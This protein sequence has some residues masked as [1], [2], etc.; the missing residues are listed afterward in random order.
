MGDRIEA[1]A[2]GAA[3]RP[4]GADD[5]AIEPCVIG[6]VKSNLGH[7][8]SAAGVAGLL[9][10]ILAVHHG[11]IPASI[12]V[13]RP[14]PAIDFTGLNLAVAQASVPW[15]VPVDTR[16][17]GVSSFGF[18]GTNAHVVVAGHQE[19]NDCG[20]VGDQPAL[21]T[22]SAAD[23]AALAETAGRWADWID[24]TAPPLAD[25]VTTAG[26][27]TRHQHRVA[28]VGATP[29]G[30]AAE[31]R[32]RAA[33][34]LPAAGSPR[35][36]LVFSGQGPS[37]DGHAAEL[38]ESEP[39]FASIVHRVD[40]VGQ[41]LGR[42]QGW[43]VDPIRG[44][45]AA[46]VADQR[47]MQPAWFAIQVGLA[48][49]W[50]AAGV[51]PA[52]LLGHSLGEV[53]AAN[54]AGCLDL[55]TAARVACVRGEAAANLM[56][57]R[58]G[59]VATDLNEAEARDELSR[60]GH[61]LTVAA[62]NSPL[63]TAFAGG[64]DALVELVER[65][66]AEG[67]FAQR[68]AL[69][70]PSHSPL[71]A[72]AAD[73]LGEALADVSARPAEVPL[74]SSVTADWLEG[75]STDGAYWR[76]NLRHP[77][78]FATAAA[79]LFSHVDVV[80]ELA[81]QPTIVRGLREVAAAAGRGGDTLVV[82]AS[83]RT[84]PSRV[85][86]LAATGDL[87]EAG[88]GVTVSR[89]QDVA[90]RRRCAPGYAWQRARAWSDPRGTR[91]EPTDHELLG[92]KLAIAAVSD[93]SVWQGRLRRETL[94]ST[95]D[96][97]VVGDVVV[98]AAGMVDALAEAGRRAGVGLG[99]DHVVE[100]ADVR[101]ERF[102][103]VPDPGPLVQTTVQNGEPLTG[104][105]QV[106]LHSQ[107]AADGRWKRHARAELRAGGSVDGPDWDDLAIETNQPVDTT[108][109]YDA[110]AE[111]GVEYGPAH[112][113]LRQ[114]RRGDGVAVGSLD[115]RGGDTWGAVDPTCLDG[116]FQLIASAVSRPDGGSGLTVPVGAKAIRLRPGA[117]AEQAAV[118]LI[119]ESPS[120]LVADVWLYD[121]DGRPSAAVEGLVARRTSF[122]LRRD[123]AGAW[124]YEVT[125]HARPLPLDAVP[126]ARRWLVVGEGRH[127]ERL[128]TGL[129]EAGGPEVVVTT[130][131]DLEESLAAGGDQATG[132][133]LLATGD[134]SAEDP[135]TRAAALTWA[136][137]EVIRAVSF[138]P[139]TSTPRLVFLTS[140]T[141]DVG[142]GISD[143]AGAVL[144]GLARVVPFE[145][146]RLDC[147]LLDGAAA[148]VV[149]ELLRGDDVDVAVRDGK[150]YVAQLTPA[151]PF[152][153][154][155]ATGFD[156]DPAGSYVITGGLGGI[157]LG[158]AHHL[159]AR[160]ARRLALLGRS[161]PGPAAAAAVEALRTD[162]AEVLVAAVDVADGQGLRSVLADVRSTL[163]P[164]RGVAHA[165]G[166][167]L[168]RAMLDLTAPDVEA[169]LRPKVAGGWNLQQAVAG[170]RLDWFVSFSS[171]SGVI[172]SPG[173]AAYCAAN[174]FLD[175]LAGY[176]SRTIAIDWGPWARIGIV[177]GRIANGNDS[178]S[179]LAAGLDPDL[180]FAAFDALVVEQPRPRVLLPYDLADLL[181]YHPGGPSLGF[182]APILRGRQ[183]LVTIGARSGAR[184]RP[185]L[186]HEV[187]APSTDVERRIVALWQAALGLDQI[188]VTDGFFELG[189]DSVLANQVFMS[190]NRE[191]GVSVDIEAAFLEATVAH[192]ATLVE[193]A[194]RNPA[195]PPACAFQ[196]T[197]SQ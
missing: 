8:E 14:N 48:S 70:P 40:E 50:R 136:G 77:V 175:A 38:F 110:F 2:L 45:S 163:G 118:R 132:V 143:P 183:G 59:L 46:R 51:R 138:A 52:M 6:S 90:G 148:E 33:G 187:V 116:A 88:V 134:S 174:A 127:A 67:R 24:A 16:I 22:L 112:R 153:P 58:G 92:R 56:S 53:A 124:G 146:P 81:P 182:F 150:R 72:G 197:G 164:I 89:L 96:H 191:F 122:A 173:Q 100:L 28:V 23:E 128:A 177:S 94:T 84:G 196:Q 41:T 73:W 105:T 4:A 166:V 12:N 156:I 133:V 180:G 43:L 20:D 195:S 107:S 21:L 115:P 106:Q 179:A 57:A 29:D 130:V 26:A 168:D 154:L 142:K 162:G 190:V 64:D 98:P 34:P 152:D 167:L 125:W 83:D 85:A 189:G 176:G 149:E 44:R 172:G 63:S 108:M 184:R 91:V 103:R 171:A 158:L 188:G 11:F 155:Q 74:I 1:A 62:T 13:T 117:V 71:A 65:L 3:V 78:Q 147:R 139:I 109:L 194:L 93:T 161:R 80:I 165:A 31:L 86:L 30:L 101:F 170:D 186:D 160:G 151:D 159:V 95:L 140:G 87:V 157:G 145:N 82:S 18:G 36:G 9:K 141:V 17:A 181:S 25:I 144:R 61:A 126:T 137:L 135:A 75:S 7:L 192:L 123:T 114:V 97:R 120:D 169:V 32:R 10:A 131:P 47:W 119:R 185:R 5:G 104:S 66:Q 99:S 55:E 178:G 68:L 54:I 76:D 102:L 60:A 49:V 79:R 39:L 42:P 111:Q 193:E 121:A 19:V 129:R 35:V 113:P 69:A 27:R 15:S 37:W